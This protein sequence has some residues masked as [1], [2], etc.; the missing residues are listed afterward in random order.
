MKFWNNFKRKCALSYIAS[1]DIKN[2]ANSERC[3]Y[4]LE[5]SGVELN[6]LDNPPRRIPFERSQYIEKKD[7]AED[8]GKLEYT[9]GNQVELWY[10]IRR[11]I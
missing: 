2:K 1:I 9:N 7:E 4:K 6:D 5:I 3:R 8:L 10:L 11:W